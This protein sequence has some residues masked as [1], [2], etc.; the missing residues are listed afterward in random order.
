MVS[1]TKKRNFFNSLLS[2]IYYFGSNFSDALNLLP[3]AF[4]DKRCKLLK[5]LIFFGDGSNFVFGRFVLIWF[6]Y[7]MEEPQTGN[8]WWKKKRHKCLLKVVKNS[9]KYNVVRFNIKL[10]KFL[11]CI[12]LLLL[13][14][15]SDGDVTMSKFYILKIKS[16]TPLKVPLLFGENCKLNLSNCARFKMFDEKF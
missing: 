5:S 2:L 3:A 1:S 11:W 15:F 4:H 6:H 8:G 16:C 9:L 7:V 14:C 12:F 13:L 10:F